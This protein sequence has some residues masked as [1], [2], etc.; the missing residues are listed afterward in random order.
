[1]ATFSPTTHRHPYKAI[2]P[3][4]PALSQKGRT[5]VVTGGSTGIGYAIARA[6]AQASADRVII[7]GRRAE[8][9]NNAVDSLRTV[10]PSSFQGEVQGRVV[11]IASMES[12]DA[13]WDK[14]HEDNIKVDVVVLNAASFSKVAPVLELRVETLLEDY[15]VNVLAGY[16]FAQRLSKQN[17]GVKKYLLNVSTIA[18]HKPDL[19][20]ANLN[21][22]A[23]KNAAVL[24]LQLMARNVPDHEIQIISFHPGAVLTETARAHGYDE[25]TIPWDDVDVPGHFAV[26]AASDEAKFLHG[27]FVHATWDVTEL[28]TGEARAL[29][30]GDPDFLKI[31]V[32]G[33]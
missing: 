18:I 13:F 25:N 3:S 28:Q 16:R 15:Q 33:L 31:G 6:F 10:L 32:K 5:V 9:V 19:A 1:M 20:P 7:L 30:D 11:N 14:L 27:R 23:S 21:Y 17:L 12:I 4:R 26:W 2:D 29:I 8:T 24:L 22:G